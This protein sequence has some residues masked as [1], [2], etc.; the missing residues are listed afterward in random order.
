M[1]VQISTMDHNKSIEKEHWPKVL[2]TTQHTFKGPYNLN[3][4]LFENT[5][6]SFVICNHSLLIWFLHL[7]L[8]LGGMLFHSHDSTCIEIGTDLGEEKLLFLLT[9][10]ELFHTKSELMQQSFS[11]RY[12]I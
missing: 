1:H 6:P 8:Q 7:I 2:D 12:F 11:F 9:F 10:N 3:A 4:D 5:Y